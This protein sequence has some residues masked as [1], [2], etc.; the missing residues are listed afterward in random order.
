M[1]KVAILLSLGIFLIVSCAKEVLK[2][3]VSDQ[4]SSVNFTPCKQD[5]LKS[6]GNS[7]KIGVEF[8]N[9]GV[10]ITYYNF[11]VTCDFSDVNVAY[12]FVNGFLNITQKASPNQADCICYSDVSYTIEGIS[13]NEVNVIFINGKQVYCYNDNGNEEESRNVE[14]LNK[15]AQVNQYSF[16]LGFIHNEYADEDLIISYTP[17]NEYSTLRGFA[18]IR[19][20][21][22]YNTTFNIPSAGNNE[23]Q[24][25]WAGDYVTIAIRGSNNDE[26]TGFY[27]FRI[28]NKDL[29]QPAVKLWQNTDYGLRHI[30]VSPF[31]EKINENYYFGGER[32]NI[33]R[34][35]FR[36]NM[37][38]GEV[39]F[40]DDVQVWRNFS[41]I[42][43]AN[44]YYYG[45][46]GIGGADKFCIARAPQ[47]YSNTEFNTQQLS[48]TNLT[49]WTPVGPFD[50]SKKR[51]V[52]TALVNERRYP[53]YLSSGKV[54]TSV[55]GLLAF[56][57]YKY[58][59][60]GYMKRDAMYLEEIGD[61]SYIFDDK[62]VA[63]P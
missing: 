11:E 43:Y 51:C 45:S 24:C 4:V 40:T 61:I 7:S 30:V 57:V 32:N 3:Q 58:K 36:C 18:I 49:A 6:A 33:H 37:V 31:C 14:V 13:K 34:S 2:F 19:K 5:N 53:V 20:G 15:F 56:P 52:I 38:T 8:T 25:I 48:E 60:K 22:V 10:Q 55:P 21:V 63:L 23:T 16:S 54:D 12:T 62:Y 17:Y 1:K 42:V 59:G 9:K 35:S 47:Y 46:C 41:P 39:L 26:S 27:G 29:S 44:G 50:F 28:N